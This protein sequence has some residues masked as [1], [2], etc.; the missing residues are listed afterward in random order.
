MEGM[1]GRYYVF[2]CELIYYDILLV[3]SLGIYSLPGRWPRW[4]N[5]MMGQEE[6]VATMGCEDTPVCRRLASLRD[7][8]VTLASINEYTV[9]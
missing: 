8:I 6:C 3:I 5:A 4:I 7:P 9:S 2:I 1:R